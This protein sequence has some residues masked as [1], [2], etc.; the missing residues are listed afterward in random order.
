MTSCL[1]RPLWSVF[2][3]GSASLSANAFGDS[4]TEIT[5]GYVSLL[6]GV[7]G[8]TFTNYG[9]GGARVNSA[10]YIDRILARSNTPDRVSTSLIG[11]NDYRD[12]GTNATKAT[13]FADALL[14]AGVFMGV[15][16]G[17]I[18]PAASMTLVGT[19]S[20][21]TSYGK[22]GKSSSTAGD[23]ATFTTKGSVVYVICTRFATG[24]GSIKITVDGVDGAT[25]SCNNGNTDRDGRDYQPFVMRVG[26]LVAGNAHTVKATVVSGLCEVNFGLSNVNPFGVSGPHVLL[27]NGMTMTAANYLAHSAAGSDAAASLYAMKT[28]DVVTQLAADGLDVRLVDTITAYD[29]YVGVSSD[30]VH[31]NAVGYQQLFTA[32][33]AVLAVVP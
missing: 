24:G 3:R 4:V 12:E 33:N 18:T 14:A 2:D 7:P 1:S 25:Y 20:S 8:W 26:G 30:G 5:P 27:G 13:N 19:W 29:P 10:G 15:P 11:Y 9:L 21:T 28:A 31:P 16:A 23:T 6:A 32:F 22:V 17:I